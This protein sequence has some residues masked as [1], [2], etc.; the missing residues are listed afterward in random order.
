M[1]KI[2]HL[3][4]AGAVAFA[5]CDLGLA[6][7]AA[8]AAARRGIRRPRERLADAVLA[9][10]ILPSPCRASDAGV[11]SGVLEA[12]PGRATCRAPSSDRPS[13]PRRAASRR[14]SVFRPRPAPRSL[15][16]PPPGWFAGAEAQ[17]V[18]PHLHHPN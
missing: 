13:P 3:L 9:Q 10:E 16:F 12:L 1:I 11:G 14:W 2:T 5:L 17:I 15:V 7:E 4:L 8:S 18:K 6:Q